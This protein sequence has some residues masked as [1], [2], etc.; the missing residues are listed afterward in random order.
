M[1]SSSELFSLQLRNARADSE[2]MK[3]SFLDDEAHDTLALSSKMGTGSAT[4]AMPV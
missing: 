1:M 3:A 4:S 2:D